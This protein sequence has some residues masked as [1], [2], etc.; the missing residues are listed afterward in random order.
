MVNCSKTTWILATNALDKGIID[1]C[2]RNEA[3]FDEN[4]S[5]KRQNLL[6]E[7]T[8][9]MRED[10]ISQFRVSVRVSKRCEPAD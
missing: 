9:S 8:S 10:F 2:H 1:F 5:T 3:I 6:E 4:N 7:L